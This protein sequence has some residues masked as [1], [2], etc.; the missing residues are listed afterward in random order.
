MTEQ[1]DSTPEASNQNQQS[2]DAPQVAIQN[3]YV[4]DASFEAPNLPEVYTM[5]YKPKVNVE[6]N[7]KSRGV[8]DNNY[9][10]VLTVSVKAEVEDKTAFLAEV[11]QAGLFFAKNLSQEQLQHTLSVMAPETLYPYAREVIASLIGRSGLPAIQ[12]SPVNFQALYMQKLQQAAAQAEG[13]SEE[14]S[15]DTTIQ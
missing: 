12:L 4:K 7:S 11:H 6:M 13:G 14:Q 1:T 10:V 8:A 2:Q 9:E 5:E 3:V 15:G